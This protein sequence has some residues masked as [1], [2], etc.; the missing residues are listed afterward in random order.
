V[1]GAAPAP[2]RAG[3]RPAGLQC[4]RRHRLRGGVLRRG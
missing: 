2:Y 1:H 3:T 4:R